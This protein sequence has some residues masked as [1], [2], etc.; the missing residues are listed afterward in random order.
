MPAPEQLW[1]ARPGRAEGEG[2]GEGDG[3]GEGESMGE[4]EGEGEGEVIGISNMRVIALASVTVMV[5]E[6]KQQ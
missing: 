4:G 2:A 6:V 1:R 5:T 3:A